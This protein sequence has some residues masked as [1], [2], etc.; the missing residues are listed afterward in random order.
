MEK[1]DHQNYQAKLGLIDLK[2]FWLPTLSAYSLSPKRRLNP[3][4]LHFDMNPH[5]NSQ[6][7]MVGD[8]LRLFPIFLRG[9]LYD[10]FNDTF[11][12]LFHN[13]SCYYCRDAVF[14]SKKEETYYRI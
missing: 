2:T 12:Y 4:W 5:Q 11:R 13:N 1:Y 7:A 3:L 8:W 14:T 9:I 6:S 10:V